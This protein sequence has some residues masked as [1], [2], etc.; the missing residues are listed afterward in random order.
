[1]KKILIPGANG[2]IGCEL[3]KYFLKKKLGVIAIDKDFS[4]LNSIKT[5]LLIKIKKDLS[6]EKNYKKIKKIIKP[7]KDEIIGIIYCLYPTTKSWGLEFEKL[8][9]DHLKKNLFYQLGMP[10]LFL[11]NIYEFFFEINNKISIIMISSIQ[12]TSAPKFHHYKKLNMSSPIE[13][14]A[15]KSGIISITTYLEKYCQKSNIRI[16]CISPGGIFD[17]QNKQ[18]V[19]RYRNDCKS[20]GLLDPSDICG[21]A[22][23]LISDASEYIRGQNIIIDDG[24]SL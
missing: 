18:F 13:Y 3:T 17:K 8:N 7:F 1:M 21:V 15:C 5:P 11:K 12:G 23:F 2:R 24:W 19:K 16:N 22:D 4:K 10:I 6:I 14:S 20:K 9:S